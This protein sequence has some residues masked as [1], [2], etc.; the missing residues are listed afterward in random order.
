MIDKKLQSKL[1]S[2]TYWLIVISWLMIPLSMLTSHLSYFLGNGI[3]SLF[4]LT[5]VITSGVGLAKTKT[6][7]GW[8][9]LSLILAGLTLLYGIWDIRFP[10]QT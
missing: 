4:S 7:S 10:V 3:I 1:L 8:F 2:A 9:V 5:A 6:R